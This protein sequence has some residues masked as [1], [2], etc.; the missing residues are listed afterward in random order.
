M[1]CN[2]FAKEEIQWDVPIY[3][4]M[5]LDYLISL[6]GTKEYYVRP[7]CEFNDAYEANLP[8]SKMF[9]LHEAGRDN[10]DVL[11][12]EIETMAEKLKTNRENGKLLTS[13]WC[14]QPYENI[15]MWNCYASKIGVRVKTTIRQFVS[16]LITDDY[17]ILCGCMNYVGY[18]FQNEDFLFTKDK[19]Y[20][21]EREFRFYFIPKASN[22]NSNASNAK[23]ARIN[24]EPLELIE[25]ITV[26]PYIG[27]R[28]ANEIC[29]LI[30]DRYGV[31]IRPSSL[32]INW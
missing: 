21:S 29:K 10:H 3:Q 8:L 4:Y 25:S 27:T 19:G 11:K 9:P 32:K 14:L 22:P 20:E 15:L 31:R 28:S 30:N 18:S 12:G 24:I 1:D 26:S 17:F 2:V 7:R 16:S 6:L 5:R 23:P 13:C